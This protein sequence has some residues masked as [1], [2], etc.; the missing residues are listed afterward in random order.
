VKIK[1]KNIEIENNGKGKDVSDT[2][3]VII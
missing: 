2:I 3:N 1:W